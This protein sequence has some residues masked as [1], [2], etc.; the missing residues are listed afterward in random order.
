[1]ILLREKVN[2]KKKNEREKRDIVPVTW[3]LTSQ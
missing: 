2:E 3:S 1:M